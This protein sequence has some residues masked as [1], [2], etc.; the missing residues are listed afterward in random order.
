MAVLRPAVQLLLS[1]TNGSQPPPLHV[2]TITAT[3][4]THTHVRQ[5]L[6]I[7]RGRCIYSATEYLAA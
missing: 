3:E 7:R 2:T 5:K 6:F 1:P 4:H